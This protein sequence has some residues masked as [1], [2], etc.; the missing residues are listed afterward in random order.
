MRLIRQLIATTIVALAA[1]TVLATAPAGAHTGFESSDPADGT[2]L[3]GPLEAISLVFTGA[4]EPT[5]TGFEILDGSGTL[6]TPTDASTADGLT[7]VL[8]FDPPLDGGQVGVRWMVKA[9]DA[10][11]ID[12]SFSFTLN[13][14]PPA[15]TTTVPPSGVAEA[16]DES[17]AEAEPSAEDLADSSD[18]DA[19]LDT[20][21]PSSTPARVGA[22][23]R[24]MTLAGTLLGVGA[25]VFAALV[26]HGERR[27]VRHVL[28]WVRRAGLLVLAGVVVELA[29]QVAVEAGGD[30]SAL[31]SPT[32]IGDVMGSV[33]GVAVGLRLAGG[34]AMAIG[35]RFD[36]VAVSSSDRPA[37]RDLVGVGAQRVHGTLPP[38]LDIGPAGHGAGVPRHAGGD[39][40][41]QPGTSIVAIVGAMAV[42]A[43]HLFDGHT[44]VKGHRFWTGLVDVVHVVAGAVWVGGVVMLAVV[45]WRRH[46]HGRRLRALHLA[47]R[48]SVVATIAL[49]A[50]AV[51]GLALTVIVLDSPSG[52]WSTQWGRTLL[53]KTVLVA[54]AA[55]G[56]AYNHR[57]LIPELSATPDDPVLVA[58]FRTVVTFEAVALAAVVAATA[59]LMGAAS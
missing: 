56:G 29:A 59:V 6:R 15:P 30:W 3:D 55:A 36:L 17:A 22:V 35:P 48:F 42:V 53:V 34:L 5:G 43:A 14:A 58:R 39:H 32:A 45:L 40:A 54:F 26:L 41:W 8:H 21:E 9:P 4:A 13:A 23:A 49:V 20:G 44:V 24:S 18:V 10:H 25:L 27:D 46:R 33:F 52:L 37:V 19:F 16:V 50:V 57:V 38:E 12:G 51:A 28:F 7:W 11:P 47:L 31:T 2:T 1:L